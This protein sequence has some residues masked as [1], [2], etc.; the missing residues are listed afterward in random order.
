MYSS[1]AR[2][3]LDSDRANVHR[4]IVGEG[5]FRLAYA[6]TYIGGNRNQQECV[7]KI[8]KDHYSAL[9]TEFY[10]TDFQVAAKAIQFAEDWNR[11]C[12]YGKEILITHGSLHNLGGKKFLVEP[13]IRYFR[14]YT[15]NNGWIADEDD[16]GWGVLAMEAFSHFTYHRSGG[17]MIVCDLQGRYRFDRFTGKTSRF[18]LTD[19]AICSRR[20]NYGITDLGEKG[21]ESFFYH[22]SCNQFCHSNGECWSR[23]RTTKRWFEAS[24]GTSM[25]RLTATNLLDTRNRA[26]FT[27]T[28]QPI[29]VNDDDDSSEDSW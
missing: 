21:I 11:W 20:R 8:F 15:S 27:A 22:H 2:T 4:Q 23:P 17:Q 24:S 13:L 19:V 10:A 14:K 1:A 29:Y 25:L 9:E 28:L 18:E 16:V 5:Q 3:N 7:C 12:D 6:G 26:R